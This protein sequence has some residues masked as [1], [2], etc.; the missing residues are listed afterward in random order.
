MKF[1]FDDQPHQSAAVS[2]VVDLFEGA[3]VPPRDTLAAQVP[4]ADGHKGFAL[5]RSSSLT[6]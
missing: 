2:A 3:L 6:I 4:G 1:R 5:E